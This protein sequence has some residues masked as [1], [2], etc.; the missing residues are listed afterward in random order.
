M[1]LQK[2]ASGAGLRRSAIFPCA[3]VVWGFANPVCAQN[4]PA[5]RPA[6]YAQYGQGEWG[7]QSMAIGATLPWKGWSKDWG[8]GGWRGLWD[9]SLTQWT[10]NPPQGKSHST[11]VGAGLALRWRADQG[12]S[13][14]FVQAGTG[15]QL[16]SPRFITAHGLMGSRFNFAS[17]LA[18]GFAH[19]A[20]RQHEWQ[21]RMEHS[22][23]ASI[24]KPNPGQN[25]LQLRYAL[26]F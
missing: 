22:S 25:Y 19:G 8:G 5:E 24:R 23:N 3:L 20:Q 18:V 10:A 14:W 4:L 17:H 13:P 21:L 9:F 15:V 2:K 11:V 1:A 6:L 12:R 7:W 16:S 26:H